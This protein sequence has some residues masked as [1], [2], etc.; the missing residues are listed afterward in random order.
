VQSNLPGT[1]KHTYWTYSIRVVGERSF[2]DGVMRIVHELA[3]KAE[4]F[5]DFRHTGG[6]TTLLVGLP[7]DV[8]I[9]DVISSQDL[10]L[11]A[12]AGFSLGIEVFPNFP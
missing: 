1:N 9:G 7:G 10:R 2:L 8:N 6:E 5:S 12:E 11:I 4:F 3:E